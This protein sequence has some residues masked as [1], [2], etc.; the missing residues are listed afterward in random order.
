VACP[1]Q[2]LVLA[3]GATGEEIREQVAQLADA[4]RTVA[5]RD[6]LRERHLFWSTTCGG[7]DAEIVCAVDDIR[8]TDVAY[9]LDAG[10]NWVFDGGQPRWADWEIVAALAH[11]AGEITDELDVV[12]VTERARFL[13]SSPT[14]C[15]VGV[16]R[17]TCCAPRTTSCGSG[18][19][20]RR[21]ARLIRYWLGHEGDPAPCEWPLGK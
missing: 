10:L 16:P 1:G 11:P 7:A 20:P 3:P 15:R 21:R 9:L 12:D 5:G 4:G 14:G 13:D 2:L 18:W 8:P 19:P 17:A 6:E